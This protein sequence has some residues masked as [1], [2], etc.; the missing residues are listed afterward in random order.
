[1]EEDI[2]NRGPAGRKYSARIEMLVVKRFA[3]DVF[4]ESRESIIASDA[5]GIQRRSL[6][7]IINSKV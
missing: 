4:R 3:R 7:I 5:D 1:V 2:T 6:G